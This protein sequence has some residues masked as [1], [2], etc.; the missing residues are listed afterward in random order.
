MLNRALLPRAAKALVDETEVETRRLCFGRGGHL[1][2]SAMRA[3]LSET[4]ATSI[5]RNESSVASGSAPLRAYQRQRRV[6]DQPVFHKC[7]AIARYAGSE[8]GSR[9]VLLAS[10]CDANRAMTI[11]AFGST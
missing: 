7:S 8:A 4:V 11:S 10:G 5:G 1:G 2:S 9:F 6:P 3:S